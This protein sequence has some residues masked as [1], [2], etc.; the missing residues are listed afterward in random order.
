[1]PE[2]YKPTKE[3]KTEADRAL[4]WVA[5]GKQGGTRVGKI[6]ANQISKRENLSRD[7][8]MRMYSFFSRHEK[9]KTARR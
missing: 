8:V 7:V 5:E 3:M 6:R 9:N 4:A 2:T 1:M